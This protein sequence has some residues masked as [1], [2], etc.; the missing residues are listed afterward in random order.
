MLIKMFSTMTTKPHYKAPGD[1]QVKIVTTHRLTSDF[2]YG[3]AIK[4]H[5]ENK[6]ILSKLEINKSITQ[7][8]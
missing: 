5:L 2:S 8:N 6:P 7:I 1:L 3:V 4:N